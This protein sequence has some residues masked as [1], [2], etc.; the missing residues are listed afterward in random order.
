MLHLTEVMKNSKVHKE[1]SIPLLAPSQKIYKKK[2]N[3]NCY[4]NLFKK[5]W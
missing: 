1:F 3:K 2:I 5:G 4:Y